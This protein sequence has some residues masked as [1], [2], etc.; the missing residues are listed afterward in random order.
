M[1]ILCAPLILGLFALNGCGTFYATPPEGKPAASIAE[2]EN[3]TGMAWWEFFSVSQI[4]DVSVSHMGSSMG[5]TTVRI[6]PGTRRILITARYLHRENTFV[7]DQCPCEALFPILIDLRDGQK[8]QLDGAFEKNGKV[9]LRLIDVD[10]QHPIGRELTQTARPVPKTTYVP[11]R[12]GGYMPIQ[13][14]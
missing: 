9:T 12:G 13:V 10:T 1:R 3:R 7:P 14:R 11:V 2:K 6:E 8:L 4:D 5:G